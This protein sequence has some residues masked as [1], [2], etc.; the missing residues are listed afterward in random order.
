MPG[1]FV[2]ILTMADMEAQRFLTLPNVDLSILAASIQADLDVH[3]KLLNDAYAYLTGGTATS[4]ERRMYGTGGLLDFSEVDEFGRVHTQKVVTGSLVDFPLKKFAASIGWTAMFFQNKTLG[5]IVATQSAAKAGHAL[6]V[7]KSLQRAIYP[8][9]NFTTNDFLVRNLPLNVKRFVNADGAAI[10]I[11][12]NGEVFDPATHTHYLFHNGID[13]TSAHALVDTVVEHRAG[14]NPVVFINSAD[15]VA[16]AALTDF[17]PFPDPRL[18]V[19]LTTTPVPTQKLSL[20]NAGNVAIGLF[21]RA[22]VWVKPWAISNYAVCIDIDNPGKPIVV[23]TRDGSLPAL[24]PESTNIM[25]PLQADYMAAEYGMGVWTRTNGAVLD[26]TTG[27][28][29]YVDPVI[30]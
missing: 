15:Q 16:W 25:S 18:T 7:L 10:P 17:K 8:A 9:A 3:N 28:V 27:A 29:A 4:D 30:A 13:N 24:R 2:G 12:P 11:G 1:R 21:G 14:A 19:P 20:F 26:F 22:V 23:R 6:N 5:D